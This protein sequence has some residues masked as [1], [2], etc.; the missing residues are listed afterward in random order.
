ME[1]VTSEE[2]TDIVDSSVAGDG[3][4]YP[5]Q[6]LVAVNP[7]GRVR[8]TARQTETFTGDPYAMRREGTLRVQGVIYFLFGVVEGLI[9]IRFVL[10]LLGA[11]PAA[12]FSQVIRSITAPF[13][14]PFVGLFGAVHSGGRV[15]EVD[16]LVAIFVCALIAWVLAR[17]VGLI[18]GET[19]WGTRTTSS[20][21]DTQTR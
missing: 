16:A 21:F 8:T 11:N 7:N 2:R 13:L 5:G 12:G 6:R 9:A 19:R 14:A 3:T 10:P 18:M 4:V 17:A 1:T 20:Q 15:F